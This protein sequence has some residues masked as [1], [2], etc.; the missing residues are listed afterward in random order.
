[1][2][3]LFLNHGRTDHLR[4]PNYLTAGIR[5]L[6][7]LVF[8]AGT[9]LTVRP[10][11]ILLNSE[12]ADMRLHN[13]SRAGEQLTRDIFRMLMTR[14]TPEDGD[15]FSE[16]VFVFK[17]AFHDIE[18]SMSEYDSVAELSSFGEDL[19]PILS[20]LVISLHRIENSDFTGG[21]MPMVERLY[22]FRQ[23]GFTHIGSME[24]YVLL[25]EV[26]Q[27]LDFLAS[28]P[29]PLLDEI[30]T[31]FQTEVTETRETALRMISYAS[32]CF[33]VG[34]VLLILQ[35]AVN[36]IGR[37]RSSEDAA[38]ER[39]QRLEDLVRARTEDLE[40]QNQQ[41][42]EAGEMLM[43][44]EKM[45][46]L[47]QVVSGVAH[48]VNTPLGICLTATSYLS[49]RIKDKDRVLNDAEVEEVVDLILDNVTRAS[50]LIKGFKKVAI[51]EIGDDC[52]PFDLAS[53]IRED[54]LPGLRVILQYEGHKV[55]FGGEETC[56]IFGYPGSLAQVVS[57][58]VINASIHGY[59]TGSD[60][61]I[62][63]GLTTE[64]DSVRISVSDKGKGM[65]QDTIDRIFEPFF[66][67]NRENGG[68]GLGMMIVYNIVTVKFNGHVEIKSSPGEGTTV[69]CV[70]PSDFRTAAQE[71]ISVGGQERLT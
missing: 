66:T 48:E 10:F 4:V 22:I 24:S 60:G 19:N 58:L 43:E 15:L 50:N 63:V 39:S 69:N 9:A 40:K 13:L 46:A 70:I 51:D 23:Q 41:L 56:P 17:T 36:R 26:V 7:V 61:V 14:F 6:I 31:G 8:L 45:T 5:I 25:L 37:A 49:D 62:L 21:S 33:L 52:R 42:R 29:L 68:S 59:G 44:K 12:E 65:S 67:T 71:K 57:N 38:L 64:E 28:D 35:A 11:S 27:E 2:E 34:I 55:D 30:I 3:K 47:G 18:Q 1:M 54:L 53:Y 20:N 16:S 32:A